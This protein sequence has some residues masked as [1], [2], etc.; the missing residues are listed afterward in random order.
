MN[1]PEINTPATTSDN[2]ENKSPL[3]HP[4]DTPSTKP[5]LRHHFKVWKTFC[6]HFLFY[7]IL[8]TFISG[9]C[10]FLG[11]I[12]GWILSTDHALA[13]FISC[14]IIGAI[15]ASFMALHQTLST[16]FLPPSEYNKSQ[17]P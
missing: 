9:S 8:T 1:K 7:T 12:R 11:S 2:M 6:V 4:Q 13:L 15:I 10:L 14:I 17:V 16:Y 3:N 5:R